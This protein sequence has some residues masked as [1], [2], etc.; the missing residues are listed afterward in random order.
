MST[1]FFPA[2]AGNANVLVQTTSMLGFGSTGTE[3]S[4]TSSQSRLINVV[5]AAALTVVAAPAGS[6]AMGNDG[7]VYLNQSGGTG[8]WVTLGGAGGAAGGQSVDTNIIP[9]PGNAG[10]IENAV[11]GNCPLTV[12]AGVA[13]TR[14]IANPTAVGLKVLLSIAS[15]GAGGTVAITAAGQINQ[16]TN[17]VMTFNAVSDSCI[18]QSFNVGGANLWRIVDNDGVALS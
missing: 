14:T 9:D 18:L 6:L 7:I 2:G 16:A 1:C 15:L 17:T 4:T 3:P 13:E 11:I 5:N 12:A 10:A 8:T